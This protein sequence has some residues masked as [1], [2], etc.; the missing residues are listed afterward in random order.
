MSTEW[1]S[2][3][4]WRKQIERRLHDIGSRVK[5]NQEFC[6]D[7]IADLIEQ[8]DELRKEVAALNVRIDK[9]GDVVRELKKNSG[10]N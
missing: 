10:G 3:S 6:A 1:D 4:L 2:R 5:G 9:A 8:I 7:R